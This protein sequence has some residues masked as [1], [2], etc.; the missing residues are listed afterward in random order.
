M[1]SVEHINHLLS[2]RV[3]SQSIIS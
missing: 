3:C 2:R 1:L